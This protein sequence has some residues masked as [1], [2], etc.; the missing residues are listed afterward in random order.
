[1]NPANDNVPYSVLPT[2]HAA[3]LERAYLAATLAL[4]PAVT[5]E[6]RAAWLAKWR[7]V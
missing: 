5:A 3:R 7:R 1:M 2:Y 4:G 6:R